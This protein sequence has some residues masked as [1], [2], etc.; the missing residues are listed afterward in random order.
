MG[1]S[2]ASCVYGYYF[3]DRSVGIFGEYECDN[4]TSEGDSSENGEGCLLFVPRLIEACGNCG[5]DIGK[6]E[7]EWKLWCSSVHSQ[8]PVCSEKCQKELDKKMNSWIGE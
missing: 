8:I 1:Q 3:E 2:C 6:P 5:R 4:P 7:F